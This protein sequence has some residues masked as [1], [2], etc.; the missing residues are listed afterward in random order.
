MLAHAVARAFDLHDDGVMQ[1][2]V[3]QRGGD[4]GISEYVAPLG[5]APVRGEDHRSS[6]VP[7]IDQLEEQVSAAGGDRQV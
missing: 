6:F 1:E 7:R 3:Q 5:K 2:P 4:D